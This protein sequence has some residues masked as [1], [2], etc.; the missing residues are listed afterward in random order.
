MK[1]LFLPEVRTYFRELENVLFKDE[2]FSYEETAIRYV[3][4]L[5][6]DIQNSLPDRQRRPAPGYFDR[7]GKNMSYAVFRK[8]R[9]TQWYAFFTIYENDGEL[10]YLVRYVSNNHMIA[11]LL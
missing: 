1:V 10:I 5:I 8:S 9:Q 11:Q 2:Y 6:S 7:Y 4:E 3:Q